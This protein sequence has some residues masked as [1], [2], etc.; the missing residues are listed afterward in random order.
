[1]KS[2]FGGNTGGRCLQCRRYGDVCDVGDVGD[3]AMS[4]IH[5]E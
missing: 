3:A 2:V 1:M 5:L 4:D